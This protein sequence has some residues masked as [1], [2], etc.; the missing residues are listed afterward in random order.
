MFF[1][2]PL[3]EAER[4]SQVTN[5]TK[6]HMTELEMRCEEVDSRCERTIPLEKKS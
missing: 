4:S 1:I 6:S 5:K 3:E 2:F